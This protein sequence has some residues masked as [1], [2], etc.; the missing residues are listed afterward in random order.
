MTDTVG[1]SK[2]IVHDLVSGEDRFLLDGKQPRI[3]SDYLIVV[4]E[5]SLWAAPFDADNAQLMGP[6]VPIVDDFNA[7]GHH[8]ASYDIST[9]GSLAFVPRAPEGRFIDR[10]SRWRSH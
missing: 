10:R 3:V 1:D 7:L 6:A 4:R 2:V 5:T 8:S 9:D